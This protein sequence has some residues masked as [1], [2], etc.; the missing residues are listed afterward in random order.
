M[1]HLTQFVLYIFPVACYT[2]LPYGIKKCTLV[3]HGKADLS[4]LLFFNIID[5]RWKSSSSSEGCV[6]VN[7][8]FLWDSNI[9]FV[10]AGQMC[11]W[12]EEPCFSLISYAMLHRIPWS[13]MEQVHCLHDFWE[14]F[15]SSFFLFT[16]QQLS[17]DLSQNLTLVVFY[18]STLNHTVF[19]KEII[20]T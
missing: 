19:C 9:I 13:C 2:M 18:P 11:Q 10:T 17:I 14:P 4:F 8:Y 6:Y 7:F 16:R 15:L 1:F 12:L 3:S 20:S 5:Q